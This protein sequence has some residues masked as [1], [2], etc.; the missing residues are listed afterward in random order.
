MQEHDV[1]DGVVQCFAPPPKPLTGEQIR[2]A[3]E[4][5]KNNPLKYFEEELQR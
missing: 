3:L 4:W 2:A 5:A 1:I